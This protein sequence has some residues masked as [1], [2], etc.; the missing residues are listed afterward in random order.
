MNFEPARPMPFTPTVINEDIPEALQKFK[1]E[2]LVDDNVHEYVYT[3][4][5]KMKNIM[6]QELAKNI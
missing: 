4:G 5:E 2:N 1:L 6:R 3:H